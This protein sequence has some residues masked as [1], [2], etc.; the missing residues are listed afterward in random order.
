MTGI[1][2]RQFTI[3]AAA[4]LMGGTASLRA[5]ELP[6]TYAG[7]TLNIMSRTSPPFDSTVQ[8]GEEFTKATGIK[9]N[10]TRIAP[11]GHYAKLMLDWSSGTNSYDVS[12]FV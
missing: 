1:N 2:R 12:L 3:A 9:L 5:E 11:S 4:G 8:L 7:T 6:R 10:I